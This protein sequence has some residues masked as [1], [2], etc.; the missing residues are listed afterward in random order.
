MDNVQNWDIYINITSSQKVGMLDLHHKLSKR[1]YPKK[2][3]NATHS[4]SVYMSVY[5]L[6]VVLFGW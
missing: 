4:Q 1:R 3:E 5:T 2:Y 6:Q